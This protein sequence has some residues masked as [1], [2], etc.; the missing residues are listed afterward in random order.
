MTTSPRIGETI[1]PLRGAI[2]AHSLGLF[3]IAAR[4]SAAPHNNA[5]FAFDG[6]SGMSERVAYLLTGVA[7]DRAREAGL[8]NYAALRHLSLIHI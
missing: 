3:E 7:G 2:L 1:D 8:T 6:V 5:P 4:V